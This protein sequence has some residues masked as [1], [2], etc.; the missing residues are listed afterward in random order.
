MFSAED[1]ADRLGLH[2]RTVRGYIRD[3]RLAATK[4]GK[5]YRISR[6]DL[7]AFTGTPL[8]EP[9]PSASHVEVT[10]IVE[11]DGVDDAT[12]N[13]LA[14]HLT[15]A[16]TPVQIKTIFQRDRAHLKVVIVGDLTASA[17]VFG[18]INAIV[19]EQPR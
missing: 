18:V 9:A 10:S 1:V 11:I 5:Q 13:R 8:T 17:Y 3:G 15:A 12:A 16:G 7:E 2:V 6:T 19:K 4:I 14:T